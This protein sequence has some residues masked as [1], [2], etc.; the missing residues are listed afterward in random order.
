MASIKIN[1]LNPAGSE[2]FSSSESYLNDLDENEEL[3]VQGGM[4]YLI[5]VAAGVIGHCAMFGC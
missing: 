2:F 1:N 5:T 4:W 3:G